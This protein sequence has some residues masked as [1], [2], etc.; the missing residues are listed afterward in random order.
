MKKNLSIKCEVLN[1]KYQL[2]DSCTLDN[3]KISC[4]CN[5]EKCSNKTETVCDSFKRK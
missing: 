5:N 4:T 2:Y 3:I 1:C